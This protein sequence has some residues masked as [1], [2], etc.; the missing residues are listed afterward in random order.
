MGSR[1]ATPSPPKKA[2][3]SSSPD[4]DTGATPDNAERVRLF[5]QGL[6]D[7]DADTMFA[8]Y[9]I[10]NDDQVIALAERLA[11]PE[12]IMSANRNAGYHRYTAAAIVRR[13]ARAMENMAARKGW[14]VRREEG[15]LERERA[16]HGVEPGG[17]GRRQ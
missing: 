12:I 1:S 3:I 16:K 7:A 11:I 8:D 2:T 15:Y 9:S 5:E 4:N 6:N 13:I 17:A 10:V 14:S